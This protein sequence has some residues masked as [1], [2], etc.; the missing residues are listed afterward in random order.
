MANIVFELLRESVLI[1]ALITLI[2]VT[3]ASW[4]AL[5]GGEVPDWMVQLLMLILGFYFGSKAE[6]A[7]QTIAR[8]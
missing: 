2:F 6:R 7:I 3:A 5:S 1:Q 4:I 8:R